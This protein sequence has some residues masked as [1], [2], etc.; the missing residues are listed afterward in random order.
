MR[1]YRA[2]IIGKRVRIPRCP[3]TVIGGLRP[4]MPLGSLPGKAGR[5]ACAHKPGDLLTRRAYNR[6]GSV[7]ACRYGSLCAHFASASA[8]TRQVQRGGVPYGQAGFY[9]R[10]TFAGTVELAHLQFSSYIHR[11]ADWCWCRVIR[12]S[13]QAKKSHASSIPGGE[14]NPRRHVFRR[15]SLQIATIWS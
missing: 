13:F 9:R 8:L 2:V 14:E 11:I 4:S 1:F 10:L 5:A 6:E 12:I 7:L 3:A 15:F